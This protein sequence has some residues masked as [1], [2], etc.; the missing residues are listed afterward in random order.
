VPYTVRTGGHGPALLK[1]IYEAAWYW[2]GDMWLDDPI[3]TAM[4]ASLR[5]DETISLRGRVKDGVDARF[6][7]GNLPQREA[8]V[9]FLLRNDETCIV[10]CQLFDL[11]SGGFAIT[12]NSAAYK[13]PET[14]A[15]V[16]DA[17]GAHFAEYKMIHPA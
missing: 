4:N 7:L 6:D 8:H 12:E 17:P 11:I 14:D 9:I 1:I 3:A 10:E 15:I 13:T 16:M 2:L 5:G